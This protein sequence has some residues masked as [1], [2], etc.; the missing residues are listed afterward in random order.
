MEFVP[1]WC[2][3]ELESGTEVMPE[4]SGQLA[5]ERARC[6]CVHGIRALEVAW[7]DAAGVRI[8]QAF[9]DL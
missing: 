7:I 4:A 8:A 2:F 9:V 6:R 5:F 1:A 3:W